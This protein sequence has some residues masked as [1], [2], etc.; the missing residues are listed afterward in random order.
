MSKEKANHSRQFVLVDGSS[1]LYR[2]FHAMPGLTNS[3]GEPTGAVYGIT[4]ML[5]RLLSDYEP[6]YIA[7][8]FDAKGKT[9]R[10]DMYKEYKANRPPMPDDLRQ[11]IKATHDVVKAMGLPLLIVE[12]V[13]ADD[14]IGTLAIAASRSGIDTLISSG[15]KDMTQLIDGHV[16]MVDTMKDVVYD[17]A[18][19]ERKFGV[20]PDLIIDYLTLV[21]DTSDNIPG[22]P[23]VGPKTATKWLKEYGSL[24]GIISHADEIGGKVGENLRDSLKQIPLSRK[25][26]TIKCDVKLK[27]TPKTLKRLAPDED[28]LRELFAGLEFKTWLSDL[29]GIKA[30]TSNTQEASD[31]ETILDEKHLDKWIKRL[32][33]AELFAFDTETTSLQATQA[34]LVGVSF[35]DKSGSA[36][37]VPVAHDYPGAPNQLSLELVLAKL[38]PILED[39]KQSKV[40]Q[41][42]KYDMSVLA[43]YDIKLDGIR[44]DTMLESYVLDSVASRHDMDS[45]ALK[46]LGE[47]TIKFADVAGKGK[48]QLS[49]NEVAIEEAAPY[50]AEDADITLRLHEALWPRL[51]QIP[52]LVKVFETI[53]M[54]LLPVLSRIERNGV[55]IDVSMLHKQSQELATTNDAG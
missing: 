41:N 30:S 11:Q 43:N 36:A 3:R 35:S 40:G 38:K 17:H 5:R 20:G 19:V 50:A 34:R 4:N 2:A 29:G 37:Y 53:E 44:F 22:V 9:F 12:G 14:V 8:V 7:V 49:F 54:P 32:K 52:E 25:L 51:Q 10:N 27:E 48:N 47:T 55:R 26:V 33:K 13:E 42:L 21:G 45:L 23:K 46:Y 31:F 24:D 1:Y 15:D 6:E 28:R 18:E 39:S 16:H